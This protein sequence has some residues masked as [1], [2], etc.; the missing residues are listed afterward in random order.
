MLV[1]YSCTCSF[2]SVPAVACLAAALGPSQR[3]ARLGSPRVWAA[4]LSG[5][6]GEG[7]RVGGARAGHVGG[8]MRAGARGKHMI[9]DYVHM[10]MLQHRLISPLLQQRVH[11]HQANVQVI[12]VVQRCSAICTCECVDEHLCVSYLRFEP[13][14]CSGRQRLPTNSCIG[15]YYLIA[16]LLL[17]LPSSLRLQRRHEASL[18]R[19]LRGVWCYVAEAETR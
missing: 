11:G 6:A 15:M 18:P 13:F 16:N 19:R 3:V 1:L 9:H 7:E 10:A 14:R 8:A 4:L 2:M 12:F 17:I 5:W